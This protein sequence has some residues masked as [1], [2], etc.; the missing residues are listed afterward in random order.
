MAGPLDLGKIRTMTTTPT[1]DPLTALAAE[2]GA[3]RARLDGMGVELLTLRDGMGR[4][5]PRPP[6][7][8][9]PDRGADGRACPLA[10]QLPRRRSRFSGRRRYCRRGRQCGGRL[11]HGGSAATTADGGAAAGSPRG[12]ALIG[13]S[14]GACRSAP[15]VRASPVP[16]AGPWGDLRRVSGP[17]AD[18]I[19]RACGSAYPSIRR[20][21]RRPPGPVAPPVAVCRCR[22][23]AV[24]VVRASGRARTCPGLAC[25]GLGA[26]WS[27]A[28]WPAADGLGSP[29]TRARPEALTAHR[30]P[31]ARLD[32]RRRDAARRRPPAGPRG[33][34]RLV[35]PARP[36]RVR[37]GAG[38][39]ARR[40]GRVAASARVGP[41]GRARAGRHRLRH[42]VPRRRRCDRGLRLPARAP[43]P[44]ARVGHRRGR[45]WGSPTG[46]A[47]NCSRAASWSAP[48]C[49]RRPWPT[50][51]SSLRW[52]SCSSSPPCWSCCAGGGRC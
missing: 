20:T 42:A 40:A 52:S 30:R 12:G 13:P 41:G 16:A 24:A 25:A 45:A 50:A 36:G 17:V 49:S 1:P 3:D 11:R 4:G 8:T 18:S 5:W 29:H 31:A 26:R 14:L 33:V 28:R 51:G 32:R 21:R 10:T 2:L 47:P 15:V 39:R 9:Q 48:P 6:R 35:H 19:P 22:R 27:A 37:R 34:A 38:R 43:R 46:G 7:C 44:A 23:A